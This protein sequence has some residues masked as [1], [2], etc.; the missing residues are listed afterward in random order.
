LKFTHL[1]SRLLVPTLALGVGLAV[2]FLGQLTPWI[3]AFDTACARAG[4]SSDKLIYDSDTTSGII[5]AHTLAIQPEKSRGF[6]LVTVTDDPDHIFEHNP[7]SPLDYAVILQSLHNRGYN[8]VI[9]TTRM[10]WDEQPGLEAKGLSSRLALF[11]KA[12]IALPVTRGATAQP[13]PAPLQHALI[14]LSRIKGNHQLIPTVNQVTLPTHADGAAQ[15]L[16]GFHQIESAPSSPDHIPMLAHWQGQGL[17]PS[18]ELLAIMSAH[19]VIPADLMIHCGKHIR[20]GKHGPI[21][22]LDVYGQ[23][24][25]PK[26]V[27]HTHNEL[28]PLIAEQ[29]IS[30]QTTAPATQPNQV[31]L[32]HATGEKTSATNTLTPTRLSNLLTLS[33]TFLIPEKTTHHHRLPLW[34]EITLLLAITLAACWFKGFPP[35]NRHFALAITASLL[36]P[37]LL[38]L[39]DI[40]HHWFAISAP[41]AALISAALIPLPPQRHTP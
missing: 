28:T 26:S 3:S 2:L 22:P 39:M 23:T 15:T 21:I 31:A 18:I 35:S 20:L 4:S 5:S 25:L 24:R 32:I 6:Q 8:S 13:L 40:T 1:K 41:L 33:Q 16:A 14:P 30:Q 17:I 27:T 19:D 12:V 36:F 9:L 34:S 37:L 7:P 10:T 38:A 11:K 29:V